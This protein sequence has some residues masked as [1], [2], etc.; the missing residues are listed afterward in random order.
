[1][2]LVEIVDLADMPGWMSELEGHALAMPAGRKT[3]ALDHCNLVRHVGM[4]RIMGDRVDAGLR[5]D[6]AGLVF[7]SHSCPPRQTYSRFAKRSSTKPRSCGGPKQK[8]P[9]VI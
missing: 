5:D 8:R 3:P 6:L 7:L 2:R 4:P 1:M 9:A